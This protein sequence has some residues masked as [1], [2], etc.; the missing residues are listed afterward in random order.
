MP[1]AR[2]R[3]AA[4]SA[5]GPAS[6]ET[7]G[8]RAARSPSGSRWPATRRSA[9]PGITP[10]RNRPV[11]VTLLSVS[12]YHD[13]DDR[14]RDDGPHDGGAGRERRRIGVLVA[15]LAHH[16]DQHGARARCVRQGRA[17]DAGEEGQREDV[18]VAQAARGA[19]PP[20]GLANFSSTSVS[21]AARTSGR[22]PG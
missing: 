20:G 5:T 10:A 6:R 14:G 12:A 16:L 19:C 13:H 1:A 11:T 2:A 17:A 15:G 18:G 21:A 22:P 9:D 3:T 7:T 8:N 4:T